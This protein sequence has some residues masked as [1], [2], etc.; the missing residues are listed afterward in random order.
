MP[1]INLGDNQVKKADI[2]YLWHIRKAPNQVGVGCTFFSLFLYVFSVCVYLFLPSCVL[3]AMGHGF[4]G[5]WDKS[6]LCVPRLLIR[7]L[8]SSIMSRISIFPLHWRHNGCDSVSNYQPHD[9]LLN[10]LF[11]RRSKNSSKNRVT[12]LCVG[13]SPGTGEFPA[14]MASNMDNVSIFLCG[15]F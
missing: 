10:R 1:K 2:G 12:G 11:R 8:I 4:L 7:K 3:G 13:N 9:C 6:V 14:Q 15:R 5:I